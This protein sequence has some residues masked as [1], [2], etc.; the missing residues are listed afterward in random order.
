MPLQVAI[1][2]KVTG[3]SSLRRQPRGKAPL[4]GTLK[5]DTRLVAHAYWGRWMLVKAEDGRAGW[6]SQ[7]RLGAP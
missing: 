4:V 2:L 5:K 7:M 6:V 3:D 1:P